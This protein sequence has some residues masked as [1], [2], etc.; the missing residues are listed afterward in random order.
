V[1]FA[2][3]LADALRRLVASA[4]HAPYGLLGRRDLDGETLWRVWAPQADDVRIENGPKFVATEHRGVFVWR[5]CADGLA[6][7]CR[8]V[9]REGA[10]TRVGYDPYDFPV[11]LGDQ[12][13]HYFNEGTHRRLW[14]LLG[15]HWCEVDGVAGVRFAVWAPNAERVSVVGDFND[16]DGR[17]LPCEALGASGVFALFVP[18]LEAGARYKYEIR[19]RDGRVSLK[20]DPYAR[21]FERPPAT[22]SVL[23]PPSRHVWQDDA[24]MTRRRAYDRAREPISVYE[25]HLGSFQRTADGRYLDYASLADRL[26][27]RACTLG[28]THVELLPITE[29]PF[30]GSWGYQTLGYFAPTSRFGT[31]DDFRAFVDVLHRRSIGVLLDWV[32]AHFPRDPHGLAQ[33][34]GTALYEHADPRLG[35]HRDWDT[36]IFNYG[37][38][39]VRAFLIASAL[40]W[41]EEFHVD[42]LRVDAVASMLYL[43]YSRPA[44]EWVPNRYGGRENLEAVDLLR[45]LNEEVV[46]RHPGAIVVAEESTAWPAVTGRVADGGLGFAFKWNMG[47]MNDTLDYLERDPVHRRHHHDRMT[48]AMMYAFSERF[49]LPLSHD[50]VVHGKSSLV[51]KM[52]GDEWQKFA[53]LR[54]LFVYQWTLPGKKLL[55]MGGEIGQ[56]REWNHDASVDWHLASYERHAGVERLVADL[57]RLYRQRR[58]FGNDVDWHGFEWLDC[59]DRAHSVFAFVRRDAGEEAV[60]V[61]NFT[62]VPRAGYRL[63]VSGPGVFEEVLN[64]DSAYYGGSNVGNRGRVAA[65]AVPAMGRTHSLVVTLPPLGGVVFTRATTPPP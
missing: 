14:E 7:H 24:W 37:R 60:V 61:L 15:A 51:G 55:F 33:F 31:P 29:H 48:F 39:E 43:D 63:G 23:A 5:G 56:W 16:W 8:V 35:E 12:D 58:A 50:E 26:A 27:E 19:A 10:H 52:P 32:P 34:D 21:A 13:L 64:S 1:S 62:P 54:L 65:E 11:R 17:R 4:S 2:A 18:G 38:N 45:T 47:W 25:V 40:F 6:R 36:L 44:G 59:E 53:N 3:P 42:G 9:W 49:V 22:A 57:N 30:D 20:S 28:F 41:L 46:R